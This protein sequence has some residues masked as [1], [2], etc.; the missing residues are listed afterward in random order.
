MEGLHLF[1]YH[2]N[3]KTQIVHRAPTHDKSSCRNLTQHVI[4]QH[5]SKDGLW[6]QDL[7]NTKE[8]KNEM[9]LKRRNEDRWIDITD[10]MNSTSHK[11]V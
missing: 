2:H 7:N 5:C 6:S 3:P 8:D 9:F 11:K 4:Y 10:H 1:L